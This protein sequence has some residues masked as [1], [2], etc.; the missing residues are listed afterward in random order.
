VGT[1]LYY[2]YI[3]CINYRCEYHDEIQYFFSYPCLNIYV[4]FENLI[5]SFL[6]LTPFLCIHLSDPVLLADFHWMAT[7]RHA[8]EHSC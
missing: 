1:I 6:Q 8:G 5:L 7:L 4:E 2:P 3:P